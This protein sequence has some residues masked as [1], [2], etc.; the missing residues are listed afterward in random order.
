MLIE[1]NKENFDE[2]TKTGVKIIEF[3]TTWCGYCKK[4]QEELDQMDKVW[5]GQVEADD[6]SEIAAKF[7]INTFPTFVIL[8]NG[9]EIE[10]IIGMRKKE[11]LLSAIMKHL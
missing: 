7:N 4:Q 2:K 3:Y 6:N 9:Q 10:R 11:Y 1:L 8:K 5:I